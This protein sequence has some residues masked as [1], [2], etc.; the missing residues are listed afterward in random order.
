L[1]LQ[2][3]LGISATASGVALMPRS[4][5]MAVCMPVLGGL[6]NRIGPRIM[7]GVGLLVSAWSFVDLGRLTSQVG[8]GDLMGP[9]I[10]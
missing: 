2:N 8:I 5:A 1:F 3:L 10:W 9:Q 7:V 4:L 6:Y